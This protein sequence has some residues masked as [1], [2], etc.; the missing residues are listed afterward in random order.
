MIII[1]DYGMGNLGSIVN[2]LKKIGAQ[3]KVATDFNEIRN[4]D[5]LILPGVGAFDTSMKRLHELGLVEIL[6]EQVIEQKKP[7]LGLCL[8]M[9]LITRGSEEG[10]QPGLG[11]VDAETVRFKFDPKEELLKIPH[12][13]WNDVRI[14]NEG[15]LF[16]GM[17]G[18]ENRF[19]FV[20]SYHVIC[21]C[22]E[23]VLTTTHHG[24]DFVSSL[25]HGNVMGTQF[26]PE[27]SHKFGMRLLK[28]FVELA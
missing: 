4:A 15:V 9:Q 25:Q 1:L 13:G 14:Q 6:N 21:H 11:W 18:I 5:K 17:S 3:A 8:G 20:H 27:K 10:N 16:K 26:H 22:A 2:M 19:Y 12:M 7:V 23:D 24:Y 28:N